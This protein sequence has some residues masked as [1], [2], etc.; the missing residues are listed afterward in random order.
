MVKLSHYPDLINERLLPLLH[1]EL[2]HL[3]KSFKSHVFLVI[4]FLHQKYLGEVSLPDLIDWSIP[5]VKSNL[6]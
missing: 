1:L 6:N 3:R 5:L 4:L 2:V